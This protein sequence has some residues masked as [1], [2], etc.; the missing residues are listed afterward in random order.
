MKLIYF[1][2]HGR[3][4]ISRLILAYADVDF[5]DKRVKIADWP[6]LKPGKLWSNNLM[7]NSICLFLISTVIGFCY[8]NNFHLI[9]AMPGGQLPVLEH[10]GLQLTQPITIARYLANRYNLAG[11]SSE[12]KARADM[13]VDSIHD[14]LLS[15]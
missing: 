15:M 1:N 5:V 7:I 2:A 8:L 11:C 4:E 6:A 10:E 13:I 12:E 3:I 14:L 9:S